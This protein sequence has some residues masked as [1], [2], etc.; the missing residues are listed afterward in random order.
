MNEQS[1]RSRELERLERRREQINRRLDEHRARIN[2]R[3]DQKQAK[4]NGQLNLRQEQIIAAALKILGSEGLSSL[5]LREIAKCL[6]MQAPTL[7]WHFKNKEDLVDYMA[8][9]ILQKEFK[10]L[11]PRQENET[12]QDWLMAHMGQLR[13]AM[14]AYPDG[15]RV[16]AGAHL[17]PAVT[18]ARSF[19]YSLVSL[20]SA[21]VDLQT[22]RYI[23]KTATNFTF[24][25]VIEEQAAPTEEQLADLDLEEI[26]RL[27]PNMARAMQDAKIKR[28]DDDEDFIIGLRYIIAGSV[29][30][31]L[32]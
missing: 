6:D 9:A 8:E 28:K 29:N 5:S 31:I 20:T 30:P 32:S 21:G 14:L 2:A 11:R 23:V 19:E 4:L 25:Y 1:N 7:Y 24:G 15:G 27:Y 16:V 26:F 12:W 10:D 17:Y 13:K 18:L 3:L 22:A